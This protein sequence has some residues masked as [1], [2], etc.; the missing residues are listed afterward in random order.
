MMVAQCTSLLFSLNIYLPI[1][2]SN[3]YLIKGPCTCEI[4]PSVI[5]PCTKP[6]SCFYLHWIYLLL[7]TPLFTFH[8]PDCPLLLGS[9]VI[10]T[11]IYLF[12]QKNI[13]CLLCTRHYM[14]IISELSELTLPCSKQII[15][16][17]KYYRLC[18]SDRK[19]MKKRC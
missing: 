7:C 19:E 13:E 17:K 2:R 4:L 5:S 1:Y 3:W 18:L 12:D 8:A 6:P 11:Q 9:P 14:Y 16:L 10:W 15:V